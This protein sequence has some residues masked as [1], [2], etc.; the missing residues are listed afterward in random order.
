MFGP[1]DHHGALAGGEHER[2]QPGCVF[3]RHPAL[4]QERFQLGAPGPEHAAG[5]REHVVG[6]EHLLTGIRE[7]IARRSLPILTRHLVLRT[8]S[9]SDDAGIIGL[10]S[11]I[12][13]KVLTDH[14]ILTTLTSQHSPAIANPQ[15]IVTTSAPA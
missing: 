10:A 3:G 9:L 4:L 2:G 5:G 12:G 6:G 13:R 14:T 8:D 7:L 1:G 15:R 11:G